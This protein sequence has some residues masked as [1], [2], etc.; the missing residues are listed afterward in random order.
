MVTQY[1]GYMELPENSVGWRSIIQKLHNRGL[2]LSKLMR[3]ELGDAF[4][5][6]PGHRE[7]AECAWGV[8]IKTGQLPNKHSGRLCL[9]EECPPWYRIIDALRKD[10]LGLAKLVDMELGDILALED[11]PPEPISVREA[12]SECANYAKTRPQQQV[13]E[14]GPMIEPL[15]EV[16]KA[17][18]AGKVE[19][20][21]DIA[22]K[23][24]TGIID[25][26]L[27]T[28]LLERRN[29]EMFAAP[30]PRIYHLCKTF[31]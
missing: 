17:L 27:A 16:D 29:G 15:T 7:I 31:A 10:R 9:P 21:E 2:T 25:F 20:I 28:G 11:N 12:F 19:G 23:P 18:R 26:M 6:M 30:L 3:H 22:S 24:V 8:K 5:R 13:A 1:D 14:V 4:R